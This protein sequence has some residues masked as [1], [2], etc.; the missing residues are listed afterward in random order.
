MENNGK[1]LAYWNQSKRDGKIYKNYVMYFNG[2]FY[3]VDLKPQN[4]F[5]NSWSALGAVPAYRD[6]DLYNVMNGLCG[7][8][9]IIPYSYTEYQRIFSGI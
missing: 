8:D 6:V 4:D 5:E 2:R 9:D 3:F 7:L 1:I